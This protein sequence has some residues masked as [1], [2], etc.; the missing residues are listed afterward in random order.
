[1]AWTRVVAR[2][3]MS[4]ERQR[5]EREDE[6]IGEGESSFGTHRRTYQVPPMGLGDACVENGPGAIVR[7]VGGEPW[8][9]RKLGTGRAGGIRE[10]SERWIPCAQ[11]GQTSR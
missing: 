4:L 11:I 9:C 3:E 7:A 6:G 2:G 10:A 8:G 5:W 1:M